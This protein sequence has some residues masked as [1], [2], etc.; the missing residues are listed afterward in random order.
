[1]KILYYYWMQYDDISGRGGGVQV[2]LNNLIR[3]LRETKDIKIYTLSSGIAYDFQGECHIAKIKTVN[4]IEQYQIVNSPMLA[5]SKSS[6]YMQNIYLSDEILKEKLREFLIR[7]GGVDVIHFH[8]LEGL[9]LKVLELKEEFPD[10]KFVISVHNYQYFCPQVNLWKKNSLSCDDFRDGYDCVDC[11]GRYPSVK[12]IKKYYIF[13]YYLKKT[14]FGKYSKALLN[15][16]KK[17]YEYMKSSQGENLNTCSSCNEFERAQMFKQFRK[18]NIEYINRYADFVL[19]VSERVKNICI[20][21]GTSR[22][23]TI[24]SYIGSKFADGQKLQSEFLYASGQILKIAYMGYMRKDK[25]FYFLLNALEEMDN[26]LASRISVVVAARYDDFNAVKRLEALKGKFHKIY[27]YDGYTHEQIPEIIEGVH[28][29]IVPVLW[30]DNLPQ[31]SIEFKAMGIPVLAS[32]KGGASELST[33]NAF[34]F[35]SGDYSDFISK[36]QSIIEKPEIIKD[37]WDKQI[38]L[39]TMDTHFKQLLTIYQEISSQNEKN[40]IFN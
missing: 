1:M 22:K 17:V 13:D 12:K 30:E 27:L 5:P 15:Y 7:I 10:T 9:T 16:I 8:S 21:F 35:K 36:L 3:K 40:K 18:N 23:K 25:G 34:K 26:M 33:S 29:G 28:L 11:L 14:G 32:D 20:G 31:V 39:T 19:C 24:T 4:G 2:Y 37:Y 6:F 38:L